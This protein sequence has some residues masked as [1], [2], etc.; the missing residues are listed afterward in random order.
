MCWSVVSHPE[1]EPLARPVPEFGPDDRSRRERGW[2]G[3]VEIKEKGYKIAVKSSE[4][5]FCGNP[6]P[7]P[8]PPR[9]RSSEKADDGRREGQVGG[10]RLGHGHVLHREDVVPGSEG[11][12]GTGRDGPPPPLGTRVPTLVQEEDVF[13][14]VGPPGPSSF[15]PLGVP[16]GT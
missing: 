10:R 14:R 7:G 2:R 12:E 8:G 6:R 5:T 16:W 15:E 1:D 11:A 4:E 9:S 13:P 3:K